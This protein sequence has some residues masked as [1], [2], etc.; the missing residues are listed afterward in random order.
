MRKI[1]GY[2]MAAALIF[3]LAGCAGKTEAPEGQ[4]NRTTQQAGNTKKEKGRVEVRREKNPGK[5]S[6][7]V[8]QAKQKNRRFPKTMSYSPA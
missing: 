2:F 7:A 6:K 8:M 1:S 5:K 3:A 4:N